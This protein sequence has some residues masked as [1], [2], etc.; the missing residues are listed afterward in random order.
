MTG[1]TNNRLLRRSSLVKLAHA[2]LHKGVT[3]LDTKLREGYFCLKSVQ[4]PFSCLMDL[5]N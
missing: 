3:M 1:C 4:H 2:V 5:W